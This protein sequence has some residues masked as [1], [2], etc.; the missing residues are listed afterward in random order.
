[1]SPDIKAPLVG[2]ISNITS[3]LLALIPPPLFYQL[4]T[5][6][7]ALAAIAMM[8]VVH[9]LL[10]GKNK[11]AF[12]ITQNSVAKQLDTEKELQKQVNDGGWGGG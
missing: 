2:R 9:L 8:I 10:E 11:S 6:L 1:M 7:F 3:P 4:T 12:V 5:C